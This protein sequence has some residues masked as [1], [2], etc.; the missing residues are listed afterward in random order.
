VVTNWIGVFGPPN[1]PQA[2]V[3]KVNAALQKT[4]ASLQVREQFAKASVTAASLA[5]PQAFQG[6]VAAE[7]L[8]YGR[9]LRERNIIITD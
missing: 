3:D 1:L 4:V 8:R 7:Y 5:S 9:L 6:F 2:I